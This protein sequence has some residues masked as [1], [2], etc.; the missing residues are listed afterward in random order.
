MMTPHVLTQKQ[1]QKGQGLPQLIFFLGFVLRDST[2]L[3]LSTG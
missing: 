1:A 2:F 3:L